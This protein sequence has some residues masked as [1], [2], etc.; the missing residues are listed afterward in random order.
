MLPLLRPQLEQLGL[1][2]FAGLQLLNLRH[3]RLPACHRGFQERI[4]CL[5]E[6]RAMRFQELC[7]QDIWDAVA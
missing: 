1:E 6:Q 7:L 4:G 5:L 3:L 2:G